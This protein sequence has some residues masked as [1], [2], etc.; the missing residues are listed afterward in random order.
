MPRFTGRTTRHPHG[1]P[2]GPAS[3]VIKKLL[4][5]LDR[6]GCFSFRSAL[7]SIW[8]MRSRVTENCWPTS[9][10]VWSL[11]HADAEAHA[12]NVLL[13]RCDGSEHAGRSLVK[14]RLDGGVERQDRVLVLDEI[15]KVAYP[16]RRR[17][18]SPG[19]MRAQRQH[20]R[21]LRLGARPMMRSSAL[22]SAGVGPGFGGAARPRALAMLLAALKIVC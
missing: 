10:R 19:T 5:I 7:A 11:V 14:I 2:E 6:L 13:A 4:S 17:S 21:L 8:R 18:A 20:P 22:A 1:S 15:A 9:S 3:S 12:Q 16:P